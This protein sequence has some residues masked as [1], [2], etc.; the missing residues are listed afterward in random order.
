MNDLLTTILQ[1]YLY[2]NS[3]NPERPKNVKCENELP[4]KA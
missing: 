4:A 1:R 2:E 3:G